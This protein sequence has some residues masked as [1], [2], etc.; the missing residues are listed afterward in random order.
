MNREASRIMDAAESVMWTRPDS[1]LAAL[2]SI[3]TLSLR[4]KS[5]RA[6]YSLLYTMALDRNHRTIVDLRIITPAARYYAIHGSNDDKMRMYFYLGTAQYDTGDINSAI[7]SYIQSKEYSSESDDLRF[8]GLISSAISDV[9]E[10]NNNFVESISY[11][12]EAID[13]FSQARDSFRL[14]NTTGVLAGRYLDVCDWKKA[15]SIYSDFFSE[16]IRDTSVYARQLLN[17]AW[18]NIF[19]PGSDPHKSIDLF[20]KAALEYGESPSFKDYC[21]FA[22]ASERIGDPKTANDIIRQL[23][24]TGIDS[25]SLNIWRYRILKHRGEFK[26]AL[27]L[28]ERSVKEQNSEVLK[29]V[30]QSVALAQSG[31]YEDKS[32]LLEKDRKI[33]LLVNWIVL[34]LSFMA[35]LFVRRVYLTHKRHW[36]RKNEEIVALKDE[37]TERLNELMLSESGKE[38]MI[39]NLRRKYVEA[40]KSQYQRLN[41][42]C[43]S[44]LEGKGDKKETLAE[45]SKALAMFDE[46]NQKKLESMLND[47]LDG[48]M[49]KI[50]SAMPDLPEKDFRFISFMIL[51]FDAKTVAR[52]MG[53][54]VGTVYSKRYV[55]KN[56]IENLDLEDK[57]IAYALMS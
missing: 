5:Q 7:V 29:S 26:D 50:R 30:S 28:L 51:G 4:T 40:N 15:D 6:R 43:R 27:P 10:Y 20:K 23:E 53:Y 21:V 33:H 41:N 49:E 13:Y 39:L 35:A 24:D 56:K 2:E 46:S 11:T 19:K 22:Y 48:I 31:Y 57:E 55:I 1:A 38:Q 54:N 8:R 14:W 45:V 34:L 3:D 9:Y 47:N 52:I 12:R 17:L 44:Y 25:T 36:E 42:L 32:I 16:P 37:V 18:G